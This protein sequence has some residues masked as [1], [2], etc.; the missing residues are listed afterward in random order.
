MHSDNIISAHS[1]F[2]VRAPCQ[3]LLERALL[4]LQQLS[5]SQKYHSVHRGGSV[6]SRR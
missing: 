2:F 4:L 6:L 3:L 5:H 1:M